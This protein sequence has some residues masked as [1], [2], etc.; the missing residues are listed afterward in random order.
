MV[1]GVPKLWHSG[2]WEESRWNQDNLRGFPKFL[3]W[4][5]LSRFSLTGSGGW[6]TPKLHFN[7]AQSELVTRGLRPHSKES[8]SWLWDIQKRPFGGDLV[9]EKYP[10]LLAAY[11]L[12]RLVKLCSN[13]FAQSL[14]FLFIKAYVVQNIKIFSCNYLL[15]S[16]LQ[17]LSREKS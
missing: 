7:K 17:W 1:S 2:I 16:S 8:W 6:G 4:T 14:I 3:L 11:M 13:E 9:N 5:P 15:I 12:K 10:F